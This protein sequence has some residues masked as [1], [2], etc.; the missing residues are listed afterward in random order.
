MN[1]WQEVEGMLEELR[2]TM[3]IMESRGNPH[4]AAMLLATTLR[5]KSLQ[6]K[7]TQLKQQDEK[8]REA[9]ECHEDRHKVVNA[10]SFEEAWAVVGPWIPRMIALGISDHYK[11]PEQN[12]SYFCSQL[13]RA[14]R[15]AALTEDVNDD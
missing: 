12:I 15:R 11:A 6:A 3:R 1:L 13:P 4:D 8:M 5:I 9:L 14:L 10:K 7:L 2:A